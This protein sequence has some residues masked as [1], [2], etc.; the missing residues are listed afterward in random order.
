MRRRGL[1]LGRLRERRRRSAQR[2]RRSPCGHL[3]CGGL[4]KRPGGWPNADWYT[5]SRSS[6][7]RRTRCGILS[8]PRLIPAVLP[9]SPGISRQ[10]KPS[11]WVPMTSGSCP[12]GIWTTSA[13]RSSPTRWRRPAARTRPS[14]RTCARQGHTFEAAGR[15]ISSLQTAAKAEACIPTAAIISVA[16][17]LELARWCRLRR[18]APQGDPPCP[19]TQQGQPPRARTAAHA[20]ATPSPPGHADGHAPAAARP[21]ARRDARPQ[22]RAPRTQGGDA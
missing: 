9:H 12:R 3:R 21:P 5:R 17:L 13:S 11:R 18:Q 14:C 2:R 7:S 16:A 19:D 1:Y 15:W 20:D 4:A 8:A 22:A 6:G 10:F